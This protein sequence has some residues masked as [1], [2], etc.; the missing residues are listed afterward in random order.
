L[1]FYIIEPQPSRKS[2]IEP[3][4]RGFP[5][6]DDN[7]HIKIVRFL[8]CKRDWINILKEKNVEEMM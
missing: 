8:Y 7:I 3:E 2:G 5:L 6:D 1:I 4:V